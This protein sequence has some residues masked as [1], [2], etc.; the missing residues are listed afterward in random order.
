MARRGQGV[1]RSNVERIERSCRL[2]GITNPSLL[3]A[4]HIKPWRNCSSAHE[5][6][7]GHNGLLL[8][9]DADLLFDRGFIT[10]SNDGGVLV[11][12]RVDHVD[13]RRLG[14]EHLVH[15]QFGFAEAPRPWGSSGLS[16]T[17]RRYMEYHRDEVFIS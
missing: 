11:S 3:I 5:R 14:F 2:T 4:S 16:G 7:D 9:P 13:M 15:E 12:Q 8:T 1:F 6:L 17:Q 10:F